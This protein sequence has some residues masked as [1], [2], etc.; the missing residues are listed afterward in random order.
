MIGKLAFEL[1]PH[2]Y[3]TPILELTLIYQVRF[4][5]VRSL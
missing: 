4:H 5:P 3:I 2:T 1:R